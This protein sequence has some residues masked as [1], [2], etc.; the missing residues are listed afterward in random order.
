MAVSEYDGDAEIIIYSDFKWDGS[1][2]GHID[3]FVVKIVE[4]FPGVK[5]KMIKL[6]TP[7]FVGLVA[8]HTIRDAYPSIIDELSEIFG[9]RKIGTHTVR[10]KKKLHIIYNMKQRYYP[11]LKDYELHK[12]IN[13]E[14]LQDIIVFRCIMGLSCNWESSIL[15][16][17]SGELVSHRNNVNSQKL[18]PVNISSAVMERCFVD[19]ITDSLK[20]MKLLSIKETYSLRERIQLTINRIDPSLIWVEN[21]IIDI[22]D[23]IV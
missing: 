23:K 14:N 11:I 19:E 13:K 15:R 10:W 4:S 1:F 2:I 16:T 20:R 8:C 21:R 18:H 9:F 6:K 5:Y 12:R 7:T 3:D 17:K 22:I